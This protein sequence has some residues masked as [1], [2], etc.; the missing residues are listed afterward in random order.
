MISHL[1]LK[2]YGDGGLVLYVIFQICKEKNSFSYNVARH[3]STFYQEL[4]HFAP[5]I[6]CYWLLPEI[7]SNLE[8]SIF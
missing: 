7:Y 6:F 3:S 4:V 5:V 2:P 8:T 1:P